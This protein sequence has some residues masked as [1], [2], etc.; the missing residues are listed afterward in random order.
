MK[1]RGKR[2]VLRDGVSVLLITLLVVV[3]ADAEE[4]ETLTV[5][6]YPYVPEAHDLFFTMEA[7]FE[8][9]HPGVNVELVEQHSDRQDPRNK[10]LTPLAKD[11]YQGGLLDVEADIYEIDTV[12]LVD[13]IKAEKIAPLE[14]P[15]GAMMAEA[16][17][18]VQVEGRTW[19]VPHWVCGNFL[20]YKKGDVAIERVHTW[21]DLLT[22]L[23]DHG[24]VVVD[25]KGASTLGEWYLTSLAGLNGDPKAVIETL[26][27]PELAPSAVAA[28]QSL[29]RLCPA[30]YCRS[31]EL[32]DRTGYY[33]R[34]FVHGK[35]RAYIGYSETLHYA[36][37]EIFDNC[38]PTDGCRTAEQISVRALP[39]LSPQ[40]KPV[41]W[42]DALAI[43]AKVTGKK[44]QLAEAF[45]QFATSWETYEKVLT[46]AWPA[47]PRYLL[48]PYV[49][50]GHKFSL[51]PSLYPP[52][53][54]AFGSR[55]FLTAEKV[56]TTLRA[57]GEALDCQL[58]S[59]RGDTSLKEQ[60]SQQ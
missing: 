39:L 3:R 27:S 25:F 15:A 53:S 20:F 41:G 56:N 34:M 57:R 45:I 35:A 43:S 40:G 37:Q 21:Q 8:A 33:A 14:V 11:Y 44:R 2:N 17:A 46:P 49:L 26:Q 29:L 12:L 55:L 28:V 60:C 6:L 42:I 32:H 7:A 36:L 19:G 31:K 54:K 52:L 10:H 1:E 5:A 18:A 23:Q 13:M 22:V 50:D 24:G 59:E 16:Q 47:A 30:G 51:A 4:S 9:A 58:P 38:G 48:P